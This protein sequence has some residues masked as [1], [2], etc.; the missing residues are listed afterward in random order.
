MSSHS[1]ERLGESGDLPIQVSLVELGGAVRPGRYSPRVVS[2]ASY[3]VDFEARARNMANLCNR[4][5][6]GL[7]I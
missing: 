2:K 5:R 3:S 1:S 7:E 6:M 4:V